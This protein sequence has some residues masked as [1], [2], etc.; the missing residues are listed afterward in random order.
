MEALAL[1]QCRIHSETAPKDDQGRNALQ[2]ATP[3]MRI[4]NMLPTRIYVP[5]AP[6]AT[7]RYFACLLPSPFSLSCRSCW[8]LVVDLQLTLSSHWWPSTFSPHDAH[9]GRLPTCCYRGFSEAFTVLY[10]RPIGRDSPLASPVVGKSVIQSAD[11]LTKK[12]LSKSHHPKDAPVEP[13]ASHGP[14]ITHAH[15]LGIRPFP[16]QTVHDRPLFFHLHLHPPAVGSIIPD[17][18]KTGTPTA[19]PPIADSSIAG[20]GCLWFCGAVLYT[21]SAPHTHLQLGHLDP[22][23]SS[24][25]QDNLPSSQPTRQLT[26]SPKSDDL[27]NAPYIAADLSKTSRLSLILS[28][29]PETVDK[30]L[31]DPENHR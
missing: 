20:C 23:R 30:T 1:A 12:P 8:L 28:L 14:P 2:T 13:A 5:R 3:N 29:T 22:P 7:S 9:S 31:A 24:R 26:K 18:K 19:V 10:S 25:H 6:P 4:A 27:R 17:G 15:S 16:S 11:T 21:R